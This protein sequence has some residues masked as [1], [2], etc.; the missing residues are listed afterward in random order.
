MYDIDHAVC[1]SYKAHSYGSQP[2]RRWFRFQTFCPGLLIILTLTVIGWALFFVRPVSGA[3]FALSLTL[4]V[5]LA[6]Y[7]LRW[8]SWCTKRKVP[9]PKSRT[10]CQSPW[11]H[12]HFIDFCL[13]FQVQKVWLLCISFTKT[14]FITHSYSNIKGIKQ[15][16][17]EQKHNRSPPQPYPG[18]YTYR[19]R[20]LLSVFSTRNA[21]HFHTHCS[22]C[23]ERYSLNNYHLPMTP[24]SKS[25]HPFI[26]PRYPVIFL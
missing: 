9:C 19:H 17:R 23:L 14:Y 6:I 4:K 3:P 12:L 2:V 21:F 11:A 26:F 20:D 5:A 24:L 22:F 8:N 13:W 16:L 10:K 25:G 18:V 7:R 1:Y 15:N